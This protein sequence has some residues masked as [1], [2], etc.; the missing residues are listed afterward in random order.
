MPALAPTGNKRPFRLI[1]G[2]STAGDLDRKPVS[3]TASTLTINRVTHSGKTI[4]LDVASGTTVTLPAATGTGDVY[5][6]VVTT[7]VTSN[8]D[9]IKVA[10]ATDIMAGIAILGQ[11]GGDTLVLFETA[12]DSDTITLNGSTKGGLKGDIVEV[13]DVK[14]GL[15]YVRVLAA[16]TS[17]EATPFSAGVS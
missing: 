15:W 13:E 2:V 10:N 1:A 16:A 8:S 12:A 17:T 3:L 4:I 14:S 9:I 11:D 5:R 7:A 6:F